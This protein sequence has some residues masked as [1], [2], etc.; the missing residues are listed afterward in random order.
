M[1]K[2]TGEIKC[3]RPGDADHTRTGSCLYDGEECLGGGGD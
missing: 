2:E 3:W 1:S